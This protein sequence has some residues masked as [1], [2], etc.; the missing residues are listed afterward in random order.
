MVELDEAVTKLLSDPADRVLARSIL[1]TDEA[2][3][4]SASVKGFV[5]SQLGRRV[6]GCALFTQSVGAVF[7]LVLDDGSE[8]A[9]KAH[10][11]G[12][13]DRWRGFASMAEVEAAY[14]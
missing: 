10:R 12:E 9:L 11:L 2:W 8:V 14:G 6:T 5:V 13:T 4:I 3:A 7:G 1:G